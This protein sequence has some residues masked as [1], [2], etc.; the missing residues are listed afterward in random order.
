MPLLA[1]V[2]VD[3]VQAAAT[4]TPAEAR[5]IAKEAYSYANPLAD[6]YRILYGFFIDRNNPEY[7]TPL[8][9]I[10]NLSRVYTPDDRAVQTPNSDTSYSWKEKVT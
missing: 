3:N 5:T 2:A 10:R 7:K 6:N 8:N 1:A 4:V 9:Q